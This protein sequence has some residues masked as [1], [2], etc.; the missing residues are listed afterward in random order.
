MASNHMNDHRGLKTV[1]QFLGYSFLK[2]FLVLK[3][4][5]NSENMKNM[6]GSLLCFEKTNTKFK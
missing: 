1:S 2:L 6:F 5:E 3:S 4:K